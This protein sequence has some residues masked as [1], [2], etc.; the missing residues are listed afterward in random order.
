[1]ALAGGYCAAQA[2]AITVY[3]GKSTQAVVKGLQ[4]IT[5]PLGFEQTTQEVSVIGTRIATKYATGASYSDMESSYYFAKGDP[6]QTYLSACARSGT[7]IQDMWFWLDSTDFVALDLITDPGG[8]VMVGTFSSPT[9][10]KNEIFSGSISIV[11]G[12]SHIMFDKHA[13]ASTAVFSLTAGGAGAGATAT[14][15]DTTNYGFDSDLGFKAGDTVII[16][17]VT[18]NLNTVYYL[19]VASVSDTTLTF[20]DVVGNEATLP[21]TAAAATIKIHGGVPI[22][23]TSNF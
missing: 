13:V 23:V 5:L 14:S 18:G 22:E 8:H 3:S 16:T 1:M 9:A 2:S 12:G 20:V 19:K 17:G 4:G 21:T 15:S 7:Q 11:V 6:T 10:Q